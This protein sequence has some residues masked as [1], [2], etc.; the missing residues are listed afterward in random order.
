MQRPI[1]LTLFLVLASI[2]PSAFCGEGNAEWQHIG[3]ANQVVAMTAMH[4][5]LFAATRYNALWKRDPVARDVRWQVL[6]HAN[7]V[8]SLAAANGALFGVTADQ[9][10]WMRTTT[11]EDAPWHHIGYADGVVALTALGG[12]LYAAT[13]D[14]R[15]LASKIDPWNIRW[16]MIGEAKQVTALASLDGK[17]F[18][19]TQ[20]HKL[21]SRDPSGGDVPWQFL[22]EGMPLTTLAGVNG[23]LYGTTKDNKLWVRHPP[24]A[25][26]VLGVSLEAPDWL[27][28]PEAGR[29]VTVSMS[30]NRGVEVSTWSIP[31][32]L[33]IDLRALTSARTAAAIGG[34]LR[35]S[36]DSRTLVFLSDRTLEELLRPQTGEIIEYRI[37]LTL[38]GLE[39]GGA[40]AP[41]AS[42]GG[43]VS[44]GDG[45]GRLVHLLRKPYAGPPPS[46]GR[47]F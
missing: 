13:K 17:L 28:V 44:G 36:E 40:G 37:A 16:R 31:A 12:M 33:T 32:T 24:E 41:A 19:I 42:T 1:A 23:R 15:L 2:A 5:K 22:S 34:S 47:V 18:A 38:P 20:D 8:A 7:R 10:L 6:G 46:E 30:F 39:A 27:Q 26:H 14:E 21:W 11:A 45:Q 4:G 35:I 9:K 43:R 25:L 29:K 3:Q